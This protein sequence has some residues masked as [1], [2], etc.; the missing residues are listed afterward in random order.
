MMTRGE[1][2][3][4]IIKDRYGSR[5]MKLADNL[6][7]CTIKLTRLKNH[8]KFLRRCRDNGVIPRGLRIRLLKEE[9]RVNNVIRMKRRLETIRVQTR[10]KD[11]RRKLYYNEIQ[12]RNISTELKNTF[13][14][15]DFQWLEQVVRISSENENEIV[16]KR[17]IKKFNM[18]IK[19]KENNENERKRKLEEQERIK[20]EKIQKEIIDLTKDG[21]DEDVKKYLSLGPDFCEAPT[22]VPYE[23]IIAETEKMCSK[24]KKDG[25]MNEITADT[26][27]REVNEVRENVKSIL[28]KARCKRYQ[29][30]LTQQ[31]RDGKKKALQD[32]NKVFLPADKGRIIVAMD[33]WESINGEDSYEYKMKKVLIDLKAKPSIRSKKDWD[34][35]E[36]V[37][38]DGATV[39]DN[40]V[41]RNEIAKEE[42]DR[43][44]PKDCHA[45]RLSGLPKIHKEDVPMRGIVSTVGSPFEKLSRYLIPILR[46]IQGRSGLY[47]KNSRELKEKIKN[48]RVERNEVLVSYD[49]KNLYPSIPIDEALR[50]VEKLLNDCRTLKNITDLS[51]RSIM[52]LLKWMFSLA[53]CEF[54]GKHYVLGSGLIGLGATGEIAMIYLE[55]FQLR[56]METSPYPLDH[57]FC[58]VDDSELKCKEGQ[59]EEILEHL[60]NIKPG[61]IVFTKED[62]EDDV[63]PVLD[64]KQRVDRKTKQVECMVHY[65]KTHTNIN[66]KER[67]NHPPSMKKGIIKGFADRARTLCDDKHLEDELKN[68]EDVFVANGYD[69]KVVK[70]YMKQNVR[71]EREMEEQQ[72]RGKV[73]VPYV[74]GISEQFKRVALKHS[75]QTAFK[76][77]K[78]V[79]DLKTRSQQP[80]REK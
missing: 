79:K 37:S 25:E 40:I 76:P 13:A 31:E 44:K 45:P 43:L 56:A 4:R 72:Y 10:I 51:V 36:K 22:R 67:S 27:D 15:N 26:I 47:I 69:R 8:L 46:T 1:S 61:V 18:L 80:L 38:R 57:G 73:I 6:Q 9:N 16:R 54:D 30:N 70:Q 41:K 48:W 42:G 55:E 64:L 5:Y 53:N 35:T 50:L 77:G 11:V 7:K 39:I 20:R 62:Q 68:V 21:I 78:K 2:F 34:L 52:E 17:Q 75:F 32:K 24:I 14:R 65:K 74:R 29:S 33:R 59:S 60:N 63:L 23:Q 3:R 66:V 71:G 49:V 19:E 58:Y 28:E 12:Q